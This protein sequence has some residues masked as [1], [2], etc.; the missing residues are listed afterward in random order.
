MVLDPRSRFTAEQALNHPFITQFCG[1]HESASSPIRSQNSAS[2]SS[3]VNEEP[4]RPLGSKTTIHDSGCV[5]SNEKIG[6]KVYPKE[7]ATSGE[8]IAKKA[9]IFGQWFKGKSVTKL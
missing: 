9:G 1:P 4:G 2:Q 8:K 6:Q 7:K 5:T 3:S